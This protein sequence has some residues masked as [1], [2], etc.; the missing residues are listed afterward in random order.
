MESIWRDVEPY[1][2]A[3]E[4]PSR[5]IGSEWG[6][7]VP[8][9]SYD[10]FSFCMAYPDIYEIGQP[11]QAIRILVNAV[12]ESCGILAER[13]YLPAPEFADVLREVGLPLFSQESSFPIADFDVVGITLP[14]ELAATNVLE[15]LDLSGIPLRSSER[16]EEDPIVIGGGPCALNPE[17]YAPFFDVITVGE[18]EEATPEL[19]S[20]IR[21]M[22]GEGKA[23]D[24]I[25]QAAASLRGQ[26]VPSL[27]EPVEGREGDFPY[28]VAPVREGVPD[29]VT[30]A[31][32]EGFGESS[33][34][35]PSIVPFC[36]I[37]HDRL[38]VEVLR[39]CARGCRFCQ[40]GMMYRPVRERSARNVIDS[41]LTGLRQTGY[42][43]ASLTS[44]STTDHSQIRQILTDLNERLDGTGT[45]ISIPSQR[46]D[47]FGLDMA[48]LVAGKKKGGLTFA[49]EAGSQKLRDAINKNVSAEDLEHAVR[50][51]V[52]EG[53]RRIKLYFMIGLPTE[54]DEDVVAIAH[55]ANEAFEQMR[56]ACPK[57]ERG[58]LRLVL[59][60][61]LFVPKA[62]TP[63]QWDG[64][65]APDEARRR[66]A[67]IREGLRHRAIQLTYHEP[68][69]SLIEAALSRGGRELA[70]LIEKA[71][72]NGARF[73]AWTEHFDEMAWKQAEGTLGLDLA[74][75]A[76]ASYP[77][78][79]RMPFD[80][81]SV[82]IDP[83]FLIQERNRADEAITTPDC[84]FEA[85]S[86]C[87]ACQAV[88]ISNQ[89]RERRMARDASA[90]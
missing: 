19:I 65:I 41:T 76:Q 26:Y 44:L 72:R 55:L 45:R 10:G 40:A 37:S 25:L 42:E 23:R 4:R 34:W 84:T 36:E 80:H 15:L 86:S 24:Q 61:A 9:D 62:Q 77:A 18:G 79:H 87:G 67:L 38:N 12:R 31:V 32:Y 13:A 5:Y 14:H 73:D 33:A 70:D 54:T 43:E 46:L 88:G 3:A 49:P 60:V 48:T 68:K 64:Q 75:V 56:E 21:D 89:I 52:G 8:K 2:R 82:G 1:V 66:V 16:T 6:S 20:L 69:T 7:D 11:N 85:C 30:K 27:Y 58:S 90:T 47:S 39:G 63:F 51:A 71:F 35:E 50:N 83:A 81:I 78:G 28:S 57:D 22:R 74:A 53:W 17:P 59:S 29:S